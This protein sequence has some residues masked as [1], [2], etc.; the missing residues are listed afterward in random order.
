MP[1]PHTRTHRAKLVAVY[2]PV[3]SQELFAIER[4]ALSQQAIRRAIEE[5]ERL[6]ALRPGLSDKPPEELPDRFLLKS[7]VGQ[8]VSPA[9]RSSGLRT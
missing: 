3:N 9:K 6:K 7:L 8:A 2:Q 1:E 4:I 5:F